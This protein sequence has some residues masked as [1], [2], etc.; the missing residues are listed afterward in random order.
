MPTLIVLLGADRH[1]AGRRRYTWDGGYIRASE[2]EAADAAP[3][4]NSCAA[5][6]ASLRDV[7]ITTISSIIAEHVVVNSEGA[8][9]VA[10]GGRRC[11]ERFAANLSAVAVVS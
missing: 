4:P 9:Q 10:H 3:F 7:G 6:R 5:T 11:Y 2:K 8:R 1:L